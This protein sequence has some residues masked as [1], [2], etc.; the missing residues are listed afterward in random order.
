M[1]LGA[2]KAGE[3]AQQR[4]CQGIQ[5]EVIAWISMKHNPDY[6]WD[7]NRGLLRAI[8]GV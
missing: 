1:K 8:L 5:R 6:I 2:A 4:K 3:K 7:G